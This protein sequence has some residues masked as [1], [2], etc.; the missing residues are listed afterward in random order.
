MLSQKRDLSR[1][2]QAIINQGA[3]EQNFIDLLKING[4]VQVE[5]CVV[6][7]QLIFDQS[8]K[9]AEN[10]YP[11]TV[12]IRASQPGK[13]ISDMK[14]HCQSDS[15]GTGNDSRAMNGIDHGSIEIV[16]A[17]YVI[18]CDG[19]HSWTR[20]KLGLSLEGKQSDHIWGVMDII[21]LTDFRET[22]DCLIKAKVANFYQPMFA[23]LAPFIQQHVAVSC[24]FLEKT[25]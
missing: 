8:N 11:V 24:W 20:R 9:D 19:A 2:S 3:V 21:P 16:K 13:K 15:E 14:G 25:D 23:N 12:E 7:E 18:G 17:K 4:R 6:T 5:R 1:F 22:F 10:A